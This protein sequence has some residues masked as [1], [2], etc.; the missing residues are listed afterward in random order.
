LIL[1]INFSAN[2]WFRHLPERR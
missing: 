2:R 1:L